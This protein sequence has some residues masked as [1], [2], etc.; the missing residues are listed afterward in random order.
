MNRFAKAAVVLLVLA[1]LLATRN[2]TSAS[3]RLRLSQSA[4]SHALAR[5]RW[6]RAPRRASIAP[7]RAISGHVEAAIDAIGGRMRCGSAIER[8]RSVYCG[9]AMR[10][11]NGVQEARFGAR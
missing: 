9:R 6:A 8:G 5:L 11:S 2:V 1:A 3:K 10:R 7:K 4:T